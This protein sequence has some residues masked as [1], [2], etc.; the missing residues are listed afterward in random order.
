MCRSETQGPARPGAVNRAGGWV[1]LVGAAQGHCEEHR[2][3]LQ[4][5]PRDTG[6]REDERQQVGRLMREDRINPEKQPLIG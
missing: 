4:P 5:G 6:K 3:G 1:R 2:D